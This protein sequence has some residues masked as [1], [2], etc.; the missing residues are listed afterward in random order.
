MPMLDVTVVLRDGESLARDVGQRL[1]QRLADAAGPV[2][3]AAPGTV[4]VTLTDVPGHHYAENGVATADTPRPVFV[5]ITLAAD[6][7]PADRADQARRLVATLAPLLARDPSHVH[8]IYAPPG[9]G[10]V[11]FGG[12]LRTD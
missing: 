3:A 2:F 8:L 1:A 10:R 5:R 11:A 6:A 7:P 4:W 12:R 9:A